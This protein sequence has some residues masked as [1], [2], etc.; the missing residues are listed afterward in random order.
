MMVGRRSFPFG[1]RWIF[2]GELLNFQGVNPK[3]PP[4]KNVSHHSE[5]LRTPWSQCGFW[6]LHPSFS[7]VIVVRQPVQA[8]I[9]CKHQVDFENILE[10]TVSNSTLNYGIKCLDFYNL[11]RDGFGPLLQTTPKGTSHEN[12]ETWIRSHKKN[13]HPFLGHPK[14]FSSC[15]LP[16]KTPS[17]GWVSFCAKWPWHQLQKP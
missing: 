11:P 9:K 16:P 10:W 6:W 17:T 1:A 8:N 14:S 7:H 15:C 12:H 4:T 3:H 13:K 5:V 2:R